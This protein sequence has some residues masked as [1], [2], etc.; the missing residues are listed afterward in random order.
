MNDPPTRMGAPGPR[1]ARYT[2]DSPGSSEHAGSFPHE[3]GR[4][5]PLAAGA[6][7]P[8]AAGGPGGPHEDRREGENLDTLSWVREKVLFLFHPE[9]GL[10][11][12]GDPA[13]E[14]VAGVEDLSQAG[15]DDQ[16]PDCLSPRLPREKRLSGSGA[17]AASRAP[18]RDSAAPPK[19]V[20]VRV[21]DYQVTQEVQW[22]RW[23]KGFMTTRT[24]EHSMTAIAFRTNKE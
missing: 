5:A 8:A 18:P 17:D 3:K 20:L 13:R 4:G 19:S 16:E 7:N 24:E 21:V 6:Q 23:T 14:G 15:G 9:R 1:G 12:Q 11:S 22:A 10:G 2:T